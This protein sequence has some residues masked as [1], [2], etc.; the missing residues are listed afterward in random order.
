MSAFDGS[1]TQEVCLPQRFG[2]YAVRALLG[3][4]TFGAVYRAWDEDLR[5][6]VAIKVPHA[7]WLITP[8]QIEM[9]LAQ[10][11]LVAALDGPGFVPLYD[12]GRT[13]DSACYLVMKF[14]PE[15]SLAEYLGPKSL[16][17]AR[18]VRMVTAAARALHHAHQQGLLH[19]NVKPSNI[20]LDAGEHPCLTDFKM[21][22]VGMARE[23][24][25]PDAATWLSPEQLRG[26]THRIDARADVYS[27]GLVL[28]G[29]LTNRP[30]LGSRSVYQRIAE[31][32]RTDL[33]P[34]NEIVSGLP[35][36]LARVCQRAIAPR[37]TER[38]A[39]ALELAL[40]LEACLTLLSAVS[41]RTPT[42]AA[43]T[44]ATEPS[45]LSAVEADPARPALAAA[46]PLAV[47]RVVPKGLRSFDYEDADF[48][49][50]LV[51]GP[52]GRD[53]LP[54]ILRLWKTR[55][56]E[57]RPQQTFCVGLLYGPSGC[58]KSS[59]VKAGLLP[60]LGT[61]V[62][63]V[64]LEATPE[65]TEARLLAV[66]RRRCPQLARDLSLVETLA[67]IRLGHGIATGSKVVI[68]L[69]Q[70]EQ[71]LQAN[72]DVE[73]PVLAQALRQ[74]DGR[75]LQCV[76]M[77]RD[78]FWMAV[79]RFM[80]ELEVRLMD[81]KNS[82]AVDLFS[83]EH[84][85][86]VLIALGRGY[87][88]LPD[89]EQQFQDSEHA[90]LREAIAGLAMD[91]KVVSVQLAL[92]A[93]MIKHKPWTLATL[94]EVGGT[95]G[96]GVAFLEE[97]FSGPHAPPEHRRHQR[98][99]REVLKRLLPD[100]H[101]TIKG[102]MHARD[103]L[104][105][106][107][108][109]ATQPREFDELLKLL[110]QE[111]R[112]ITP[113][114]PEGVGE[115]CNP[116]TYERQPAT[117]VGERALSAVTA[118]ERSTK[119]YYQLTH[120]FL[121]LSIRRWLIRKQQE[122]RRGRAEL[123][124]AERSDE[125]ASR[126]E[127]RYLPS[128][129]QWLR[130]RTVTSRADWNAGERAMMRVADRFHAW[131]GAFVGLLLAVAVW[132]GYEG[133]QHV[134]AAAL[135]DRLLYVATDETPDVIAEI[136]PYQR[137]V[138]PLLSRI[139]SDPAAD[140][141]EVLHARLGL[142]PIDPSQAVPLF[143]SA[144][145][146]DDATLLVVVR[147]LAGQ[148][149]NLA[150]RSW[151]L[152]GDQQSPGEHRLRAAIFL[153]QEAPPFDAVSVARWQPHRATIAA[154]LHAAVVGDPARY[155]ALVKALAPISSLLI[156]PL[157]D[158]AR[159]ANSSESQRMIA[160][161]ILLEYAAARADVLTEILREGGS[162]ARQ[163]AIIDR[164]TPLR[165]HA[166][167]LLEPELAHTISDLTPNWNDGVSGTAT[168]P[169]SA[170]AE[171]LG[172]AAGLLADRFAFCQTL[173]LDDFPELTDT[174]QTAGY[175]PTRVRPYR[176][177]ETVRVA[178]AWVRDGRDGRSQWNLSDAELRQ[179][180]EGQFMTV[181]LLV[182]IASY[183]VAQ[184][185][186]RHVAV[187]STRQEGDPEA[188]AYLGESGN[189][190]TQFRD[191]Q[192]KDDFGP[193][194][195]DFFPLPAAG[196][197][198]VAALFWKS[199]GTAARELLPAAQYERVLSEELA[200]QLQVSVDLT[201]VAT[202]S[203][204]EDRQAQRLSEIAAHSEQIDRDPSRLESWYQR[205]WSCFYLGRDEE[206][207][208]DFTHYISGG[209]EPNIRWRRDNAYNFRAVAAAR[210]GRK[211]LAEQ[212]LAVAAGSLSHDDYRRR[213][214]RALA[215]VT[216][217]TEYKVAEE[218]ERASEPL[219]GSAYALRD[220]AWVYGWAAQAAAAQAPERAR[221]F[222]DKALSFLNRAVQSGYY[223][224]SLFVDPWFATIRDDPRSQRLQLDMELLASLPVQ[225]ARQGN[226]T[227][228]RLELA[229]YQQANHTAEEK[230]RMMAATL[231]YLGE[232]EQAARMIEAA[233]A[234]KPE[235]DLR[236]YWGAACGYGVLVHA[237]QDS[238]PDRADA[239]RDRALELIYERLQR[240]S[241]PSQV[242]FRR[243]LTEGASQFAPLRPDPR[244]QAAIAA[245]DRQYSLITRG[246]AE[247]E[248]QELHG[249]T[250]QLHLERARELT[251]H[252]WRLV[253][254]DACTLP[255]S[256]EPAIASIWHRPRVTLRQQEQCVARQA[257]AAVALLRLDRPDSVWPLLNES[258]DPR[259]RTAIGL[260]LGPVGTDPKR[261]AQ[262]LEQTLD[263]AIRRTLVLAL[264][265]C[266][267]ESLATADRDDLAERLTVVF[268]QDA[269]PG[270]HSAA[271]WTLRKWGQ[272][273]QLAT[274]P[275]MANEM[276]QLQDLWTTTSQGHTLVRVTGP[277]ETSLGSP[278]SE[279]ARETD[280]HL[281]RRLIPWSYQIAT[282]EVTVQ[283]FQAFL[284]EH[285][286]VQHQLN[287][288]KSPQPDCPVN[289]VS[290]YHVAQYCR[291]LSEQE[292]L[293]EDEMVYPPI[294]EIGAGMRQVPYALFRAAY[295]IPTEAEWEHA[296]RAGTTT[297]RYYG[298][299][300]ELLSRFAWYKGNSA[301][302]SWPVGL[303]RPNALGLFDMYGNI[304][305]YCA[306]YLTYPRPME[307]ELTQDSNSTQLL[308]AKIALRGGS[309]IHD[310]SKLRS[311]DR[312]DYGTKFDTAQMY[313]GFRVARTVPPEEVV[314]GRTLRRQAAE[315]RRTGDAA[316]ADAMYAQVIAL[317]QRALDAHPENQDLAWE[318]S[319]LLLDA[320]AGWVMLDVREAT[321]TRGA[322]LTV[323][324][325]GSILAS[326]Q[327]PE[328]EQDTYTLVAETR[329][330]GITGLLLESQI[331]YES[332]ST[333]SDHVE[334]AALSVKPPRLI[335][336]ASD[337]PPVLLRHSF[338]TGKWR[339]ESRTDGDVVL[340]AES[341]RDQMA[342]WEIESP[343]SMDR[344]TLLRVLIPQRG[345][346][347][348]RLSVTRRPH[349]GTIQQ[350]RHDLARSS[351]SG[352]A[353]LACA[354]AVLG[355]ADA[356]RTSLAK[357]GRQFVGGEPRDLLL[358]ANVHRLLGSTDE[359][360]TWL[361]RGLSKWDEK[362][363]DRELKRLLAD[364]LAV[365][366]TDASY[367]LVRRGHLLFESDEVA[368]AALFE[369]HFEQ[370]GGDPA[371][372]IQRAR[373]YI[374]LGRPTLADA[375][376]LR[377]AGLVPEQ[378]DQFLQAG[379]WI[380][381]P[382]RGELSEAYPLEQAADPA[383]TPD[384]GEGADALRWQRISPHFLGQV[385]VGALYPGDNHSVYLLTYIY[386]PEERTAAFA[387][388]G[389][390]Q[391]R[392]WLNGSLI[393]EFRSWRGDPAELDLV[394]VALRAGR[395]TVLVKVRNGIGDFNL[396]MRVTD[397]P[398][399]QGLLLA[400]L[401]LWQE[402]APLLRRASAGF[403]PGSLSDRNE[404]LLARVFLAA[405]DL[406]GYREVCQRVFQ[407]HRTAATPAGAETMALLAG[408]GDGA[409]LKPARLAELADI[410]AQA[411]KRESW[412]HFYDALS[413]YRAGNY[414]RVL[415][416]LDAQP[417]LVRLE[418][419]H[420][421]RALTNFRIGR[422]EEA[423]RALATASEHYAV[424]ADRVLAAGG[425]RLQPM[426]W[427]ELAELQIL[428]REARQVIE[429]AG[430]EA[431]DPQTRALVA[432]ARA[433][434]QWGDPA[435]REFDDALRRKP[436]VAAVWIARARRWQ[437][438]DQ[439]VR[440]AADY[441]KAVQL[442]PE[443]TV[444]RTELE[445]LWS[446]LGDPEE[447]LQRRLEAT[448]LQPN[449][450]EHW[451][452]RARVWR[453]LQNREAAARDLAKALDLFPYARNWESSN[454][455]APR[456]KALREFVKDQ[457]VWMHLLTL[458][459]NDAHLRLV[460]ARQN[461]LAGRWNRAC[462]GYA[463]VV[464]DW[465]LG[466]EA[467]EYAAL[468]WLT[469]ER[470]GYREFLGWMIERFTQDP[471][472]ANGYA[473]ARAAGFSDTLAVEPANLITWAD[474]A[475]KEDPVPWKLHVLG[476]ALLRAGR[477]EEGV[478]RL[479]ASSR[480]A[481]WGPQ[482]QAQNELGLA[483][484]HAANHDFISA[485]QVLDQAGVHIGT[486]SSQC[487]P[488]DW[489]AL[490]VLRRQ[491]EA[492]VWEHDL[493]EL[494]ERLAQNPN[495]LETLR[496]H[497][498][499]EGR[500]KRWK[501]AAA[502]YRRLS[503]LNE[504]DDDAVRQEALMLIQLGDW[505]AAAAAMQR[506]VRSKPDQEQYLYALFLLAMLADAEDPAEYYRFSGEL[507]G[508]VA[509]TEDPVVAERISKGVLLRAPRPVNLD[510]VVGL[511]NR[512][513]TLDS[514][515]W[516]FPFALVARALAAYRAGDDA[517]ALQWAERAIQ[518]DQGADSVWF[519]GAQA[520]MVAALAQHRLGRADAALAALER[521]ASKLQP[522]SD[523]LEVTGELNL[524][525]WCNW[526]MS[527]QL[528][529]EAQ[530]AL[531]DTTL[532]TFR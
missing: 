331:D 418:K 477:L 299:S 52:R 148:R 279:G 41:D 157:Q 401:G 16:S 246:D 295:R 521:A 57:T 162:P 332:A 114:D 72:R 347:K 135:R 178:A 129:W 356:C 70:F 508:R 263:P 392:V 438:L 31:A 520:H 226:A 270:V 38:Y 290:W 273:P 322:T 368:A 387:V 468:L 415:Q 360:R 177:G 390:D 65:G 153:A 49:L 255:G 444:I 264:G 66:L 242:T 364:A 417:Q 54:E 125:W 458:R 35:P 336:G 298:D 252:N 79:T 384:V 266:E 500:L 483:L 462:A 330:A 409:G 173:P 211:D 505:R 146:V 318:L 426:L 103:E 101:T 26:E 436:D 514:K 442:A 389:D 163:A 229:Q 455:D 46:D 30:P 212:F 397:N 342:V 60:R 343:P 201:A 450:S 381:G 240:H 472:N 3:S 40:E 481:G 511:A 158:R 446:E 407:V 515:H 369:H 78:D 497:A 185:G 170:V 435:V 73:R 305:E 440:A 42:R 357:I 313:A 365:Q 427:W 120:D 378:L 287:R 20:L 358:L 48:F 68:V 379:W 482:Q 291:W 142:L 124:L 460:D 509:A 186:I 221:Q 134:R 4:G 1:I 286:E 428:Y 408:L 437:Q 75:R 189:A 88:C 117:D 205:G 100:Q 416:I 160:G 480:A 267:W 121:V 10:A 475:A 310:P 17:A 306:S 284:A 138:T 111:L 43:S 490:Q 370:Q 297:A 218:F 193:V 474:N 518:A 183:E 443:D 404:T 105:E 454:W 64:Y 301:E 245:L 473:V 7:R 154:R 191:Q 452:E 195:C 257:A 196:R 180:L 241:G 412:Q 204:Y 406:D 503:E 9:Y 150:E 517:G 491:V 315:L 362:T 98:A 309:Y 136:Q 476:I 231:G 526:R 112:L 194:S 145:S 280:E 382:Y 151:T 14:I 281:H 419:S 109:Y 260:S 325:D 175:R 234:D 308:A 459:P 398:F 230:L 434:R 413:H 366:S 58:G 102:R 164:L 210:L 276:L 87:G 182:D 104:L 206:A 274:S 83:L 403:G 531:G 293:P 470:D 188:K 116:E 55:L 47:A 385:N 243:E 352:W 63:P 238:K 341:G 24:V 239:Y 321:S 187:W 247:L 108:G 289:M 502:H 97:T 396:Q 84:A 464:H 149:G 495:D 363:A 275:S 143:E 296:C 340:E 423:G 113:A 217:D 394:P 199:A 261:L 307:P 292:G 250:P 235:D 485:A 489:A 93:E 430:S 77:A 283:Q 271:E 69:D 323:Q 208:R 8:E 488:A 32:M 524:G 268:R 23:D 350:W 86:K 519:R 516:I 367:E 172:A 453:A 126:R 99:A 380:T 456:S 486:D 39:T 181:E 13:E 12:A 29:V 62:I 441:V 344:P 411:P 74:C 28:Y 376:Y 530:D 22:L 56:E 311:A 51:P 215:D 137:W 422:A 139:L 478:D 92:F 15:G 498:M 522:L 351:L 339:L 76:V 353:R 383:R 155:T 395:N 359:A 361:D 510:A 202:L 484:L 467:T 512:A 214:W 262:R 159:D 254:I 251:A 304:H 466:D 371:V 225:R 228:A 44:L 190:W 81:G 130:I 59:L 492:I 393:H 256:S 165:E 192:I 259:L 451:F 400:E 278:L 269:D 152:L 2:R 445:R 171:R 27:L 144:L 399:D 11:R 345:L 232:D 433:V 431:E 449:Q 258:P 67:E 37:V 197:Y 354:Q 410:A 461:L 300:D 5:R 106:A 405:G 329:Q 463:A 457:E 377:A 36:E 448:G 302:H 328:H 249:M 216:T 487:W 119:L 494:A 107:S 236:R 95:A 493:S 61:H 317:F 224:I 496:R 335:V 334:P 45:P 53:G 156:D 219:L 132:S 499:L 372:L 471:T 529:R 386:S 179:R 333:G 319:D 33:P 432:A 80:Q 504:Q 94:K 469:G 513:V 222:T 501:A 314:A 233:I 223:A 447:A 349:A 424:L 141:R 118:P 203:P 209:G 6:D 200:G 402:A 479:N 133:L 123:L 327:R 161:N 439:P 140:P 169:D 91:G 528:F 18:S 326:G 213:L 346:T 167:A 316:Q 19:C 227:L 244:F 176:D 303:L 355:Q 288:S 282:K 90:F 388:G 312:Y 527:V 115:E 21:P 110:D 71:W 532:P 85:R 220:V 248:S 285:P 265:E 294:P 375:D 147:V 324:K 272:A 122:T 507:L 25:P 89:H 525:D 506:S 128:W 338:A 465:P 198:R 237:V 348:L 50:E 429:G 420:A 168:S 184:Q 127:R 523:Q 96:I 391:V 277:L 414:D 166:V 82:A 421:L 337:A 373:M 174:L 320:A 34:V 425:F 374:E 131:R 253:A 207:I